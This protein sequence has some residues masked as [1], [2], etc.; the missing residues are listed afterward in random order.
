MVNIKTKLLF[1]KINKQLAIFMSAVFIVTLAVLFFVAVKTVYR[2][3]KLSAENY[4]EDNMLDD[5]VLFGMFNTNDIDTLEEING[6]D[7]VEA[8]HR[9]QGKINNIDA[10]IY[11]TDNN[12]QAVASTFYDARRKSRI[13]DPQRRKDE[14]IFAVVS[15]AHGKGCR[16]FSEGTLFG[17]TIRICD[18]QKGN[19]RPLRIYLHFRRRKPRPRLRAQIGFLEQRLRHGSGSRGFTE[20]ARSGIQICDRDAR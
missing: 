17:E 16:I 3:F 4:F 15:R 6:I 8:K 20:G 18:L 5:L 2:D 1:R 14:R 13:R 19:K 7:K 10:I 9:F 12:K 11:G